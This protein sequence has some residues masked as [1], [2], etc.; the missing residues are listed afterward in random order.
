MKP[1]DKRKPQATPRRQ[2][3]RKTK[4]DFLR[5]LEKRRALEK[6]EAEEKMAKA[7]QE[8]KQALMVWVDDGGPPA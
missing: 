8:M 4:D 2:T 1:G 6:L 7:A 3:P 5:W